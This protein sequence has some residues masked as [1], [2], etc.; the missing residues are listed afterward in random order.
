MYI[1]VL[2]VGGHI[3]FWDEDPNS[4]L[5]TSAHSNEL[6]IPA[7]FLPLKKLWKP[8]SPNGGRTRILT[9]A[10]PQSASSMASTRASEAEM[11]QWM[12]LKDPEP[13]IH[14]EMKHYNEHKFD[15]FVCAMSETSRD[16]TYSPSLPTDGEC[17]P[18]PPYEMDQWMA[19]KD[20]EPGERFQI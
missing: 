11:D 14:S 13:G 5:A 7:V 3:F 20:P 10:H 17:L 12:A 6:A 15:E 19:L 4:A 9:V 2:T 18:S 16:H 1:V 8:E